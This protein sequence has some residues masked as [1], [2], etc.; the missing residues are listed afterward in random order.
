MSTYTVEAFKNAH[1]KLVEKNVLEHIKSN[2]LLSGH[3]KTQL[4][5]RSGML[6][7][8]EDGSINYYETKRL[9][10]KAIDSNILAYYNTDGSVN[11]AIGDYE[12]F[13][14][15]YNEDRNNWTMITYKEPSWYGISI[16]EKRKMAIDGFDRKYK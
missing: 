13:V 15:C 3:A 6:I 5:K 10:N 12:Y 1:G 8:R 16:H 11:I 4:K 14:F 2:Y 9:I 7:E